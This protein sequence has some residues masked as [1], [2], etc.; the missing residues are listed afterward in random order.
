MEDDN[1]AKENKTRPSTS[2]AKDR[3]DAETEEGNREN[4]NNND[5]H[6]S[7]DSTMTVNN[8]VSTSFYTSESESFAPTPTID[9][10]AKSD[11][12]NL[13]MVRR[14]AGRVQPKRPKNKRRARKT[15][16]GRVQKKKRSR[17]NRQ[18]VIR[19]PRRSAKRAERRAASTSSI[20]SLSSEVSVA[21]VCSHCGHCC[22]RWR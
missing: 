15:V 22:C 11:E 2:K 1:E 5:D 18:V 7:R 6:A 4:R 14:A 8:K 9:P 10:N 3:S 21:Q 19:A 17:A 16:A 20:Y 13:H 12:A